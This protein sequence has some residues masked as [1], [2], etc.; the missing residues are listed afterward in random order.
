[1][2][3]VHSWSYVSLLELCGSPEDIYS[4]S[5]ENECSPVRFT[6]M[7]SLALSEIFNERK[8]GVA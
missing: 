6:S 2:S 4:D 8:Q 7:V 5:S 3:D 1:M